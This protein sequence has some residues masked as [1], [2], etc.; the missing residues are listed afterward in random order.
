MEFDSA[1]FLVIWEVTQACDLACRHCRAAAQPCRHPGELSTAEGR[2]LLEQLTEFGLPTPE[3]RPRLPLLVFTGGDPIKRPDIYDLVAHARALGLRPS[4]SPSATPLVTRAVVARLKEVGLARMAVSLDGAAAETHDRFRGVAGSYAAT[5]RIVEWC[6]EVELSLQLNTTITRHNLAELD[7][8]A[9]LIATLPGVALWS[10]FFLVPTG[11]GRAEDDITPGEYERVFHRLYELSQAL[12]FDIKTTAAQ[13]YRR[14][15]LQHRAAAKRNGH[16]GPPLTLKGVSNAAA[17]DIGRATRGVN[18]GNGFLFISHLGDIMPSGFLPIPCGNVRRDH[19]VEIYRESPVF[20][21]LRN[22]DG[23]K[24]KCGACE[25]RHVCGGSRARA[26]A[27][28]GDYLESEPNCLY[29][30][31]AWRRQQAEA[32]SVSQACFS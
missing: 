13:H 8:I 22:P 24:G 18:D 4:L 27:L 29:V 25:F 6:R 28:T 15:A 9:A 17:G 19:V 3:G 2:R 30:P 32:A 7:D 31:R 14:V 16:A 20:R 5:L 1:P 11:R 23:Y 12:P 21:A 10:V 26:Y